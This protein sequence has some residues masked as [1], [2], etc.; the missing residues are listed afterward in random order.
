MCDCVVQFQLITMQIHLFVARHHHAMHAE[1][2]I[3]MAN[4]SV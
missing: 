4:M 1:R 2:D 3:A